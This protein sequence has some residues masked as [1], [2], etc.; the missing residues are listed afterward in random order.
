MPAKLNRPCLQP[1]CP[2]YA[3]PGSSRCSEHALP[4]YEK[5]NLANAQFYQSKDW[6]VLRSRWIS[7]FPSCKLCGNKATVVD[8]IKPIRLGGEALSQSNLQ[9]LCQRCHMRKNQAEARM[10][11]T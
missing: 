6:R 10:K 11:L 4:R 5:R 3:Q 1:L 2:N 7:R 8:H 9:S